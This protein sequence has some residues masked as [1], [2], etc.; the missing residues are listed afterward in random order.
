[1]PA[2]FKLALTVTTIVMVFS[3][4]KVAQDKGIVKKGDAQ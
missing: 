3:G 4:L 2:W 1:M